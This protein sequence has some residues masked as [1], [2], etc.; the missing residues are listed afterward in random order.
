M[1]SAVP[2]GLPYGMAQQL[3]QQQHAMPGAPQPAA[4]G[5]PGAP[6]SMGMPGAPGGMGVSPEALQAATDYTP[7][8]MN[9]GG[10]SGRPGEPV[11]HG[12]MSGPG[13]GPEALAPPRAPDP[14]LSGLS[15]LNQLGDKVDPDTAHLRDVVQA[16]IG[17]RMAQ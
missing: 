8:Q 14:L 1:P 4:P 2:T 15:I 12:A 6:P 11:T 13:G 10:P 7:P 9:L 16:M 5:L 3:A 17:N